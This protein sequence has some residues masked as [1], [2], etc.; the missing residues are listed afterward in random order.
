M[1]K[2][3]SLFAALAIGFV[4]AAGPA[5]IAFAQEAEGAAEEARSIPGT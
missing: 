4:V 2:T 1:S 5:P 3:G